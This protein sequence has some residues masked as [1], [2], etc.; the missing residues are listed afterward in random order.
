MDAQVKQSAEALEQQ[1]DEVLKIR[2]HWQQLDLAIQ[3]RSLRSRGAGR[4]DAGRQLCD[5]CMQKADSAAGRSRP[6]TLPRSP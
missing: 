1:M 5:C 6:T 3:H 4:I 2:E